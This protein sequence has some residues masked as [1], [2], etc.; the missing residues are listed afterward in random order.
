VKPFFDGIYDILPKI[1]LCISR[2]GA[3][4]IVDLLAFGVPTIFIPLRTSADDHQMK[5][6]NWVVQNHLGFLHKPWESNSY[7]LTAL[8]HLCSSK[9][10]MEQTEYLGQLAI[11]RGAS[12]RMSEEIF[13][14][15]NYS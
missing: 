5:N 1:D 8:M 12:E 6:A 4:S 9:S 3:S 14:I 13:G 2:S 11:K 15:S 10:F 7:N